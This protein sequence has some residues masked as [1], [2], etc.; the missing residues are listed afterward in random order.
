MRAIVQRVKWARVRVGDE[1][2]G[3]IDAGLLVLLGAARGDGNPEAEMLAQ[4]IIGL[5]I[6][7][8]EAGKMNRSVVDIGGACLVVSQFTLFA[9]CRKGRRPFF[10]GAE[11]PQRATELCDRFATTA[12]GL[13]VEVA[14]GRFGAMM[15]V[16]LCNDGPV[17]IPLDSDE[18]K[19]P[20]RG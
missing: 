1:T 13:G 8:D 15:Q 11:E 2:V 6:F 12:R 18:L 16:E 17:T 9:D 7:E 20:R 14:T 3:S 10:G 4:K 19:A 5:R